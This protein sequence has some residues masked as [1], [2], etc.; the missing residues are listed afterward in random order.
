MKRPSNPSRETERRLQI[1]LS[2][3]N[4]CRALIGELKTRRAN[5]AKW[6]ITINLGLAAAAV[7]LKTMR[8]QFSFC[9]W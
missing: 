1:T 4:D 8:C 2:F 6:V 9:R 5:A 3:L 7:A